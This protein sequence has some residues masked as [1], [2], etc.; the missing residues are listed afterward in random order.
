M[1]RPCPSPDYDFWPPRIKPSR[2]ACCTQAHVFGPADGSRYAEGRGYIPPDAPIATYLDRLESPGLDRGVIVHGSAHC[3]DHRASLDG[4]ATAPDPNL[5]EAGLAQ[6]DAGGM[7]GI[8]RLATLK[9]T[10]GSDQLW[11]FGV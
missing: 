6:L 2:G 11:G 3:S 7:R 8:R 1:T 4:I 10:V 9:G 5:D